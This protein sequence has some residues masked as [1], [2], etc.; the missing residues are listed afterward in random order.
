MAVA[1]TRD[2]FLW[3]ATEEGLVRFNGRTFVTFDE[4]NAPGLGDRFIRSLATGPDGSL[5]I[6]T[7]SGLARYSAGKFESFRSEAETRMDTESRRSL[8]RV[9]DFVGAKQ[10][11]DGGGPEQDSRSNRD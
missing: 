10:R 7:M 5:W 3:L 6:G 4:R 9:H 2:G 8:Q 11:G 1:Q